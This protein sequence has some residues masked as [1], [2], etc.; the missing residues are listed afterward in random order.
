[1]EKEINID[2]LIGSKTLFNSLNVGVRVASFILHGASLGDTLGVIT[3]GKDGTERA[4]LGVTLQENVTTIG[5]LLLNSDGVK[6][7]SL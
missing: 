1:M 5:A 7:L 2:I 3:A 4:S 6:G